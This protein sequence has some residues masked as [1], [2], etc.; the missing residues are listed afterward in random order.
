MVLVA[1]LPSSGKSSAIRWLASE[2]GR[3]R[4]SVAVARVHC[5]EPAVEPARPEV[6]VA[7]RTWVSGAY[8]PDH[9]LVQ[10]LPEAAEWAEQQQASLL[11]VETAGLCG[12]CSPFTQ[13]PLALFVADL[14]MGRSAVQ[15][16]GPM[17]AT[18]DI[19]VLTRVDRV[20]WTELVMQRAT[21]R[22]VN[23]ECTVVVLNGLTG[24]GRR[25]LWTEVE[26]RL[27]CGE[28]RAHDVG[29]LRCSAP[30]FYCSFCLGQS[31]VGIFQL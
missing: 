13:R 19:C 6:A 14:S 17:L 11:L 18:C 4:Q 16:V 5:F 31:R 3:A 26:R 10:K 30:Q 27:P 23:P 28:V 24:E 29:Q 8:C 12:R 2:A 22:G 21:V 15:K 25:E 20:S 9:F 1:G 7:S